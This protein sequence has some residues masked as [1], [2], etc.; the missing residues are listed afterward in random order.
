M[1]NI[2]YNSLDTRMEELTHQLKHKD[3]ELDQ[4]LDEAIQASFD[5]VA[6]KAFST[7]H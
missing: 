7:N 2:S 6:T 3:E 1:T 4:E 5:E